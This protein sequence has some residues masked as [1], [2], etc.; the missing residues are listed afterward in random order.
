MSDDP[1]TPRRWQRLVGEVRGRPG[2]TLHCLGGIHGNEPAGLVAAEV[3]LGT[4]RT[5]LARDPA[6]LRGKL[7]ALAGNLEALNAGDPGPRYFDRDLNRMFRAETIA[8]ARRLPAA[9]RSPEQGQLLELV[10]LLAECAG[11]A[12]PGS[13]FLDLHTFSSPGSPFIYVEDSLPARRAGLALGLPLVVGLEEELEGLMADYITAELGL[14]ALVAE[15]GTHADPGSVGVHEAV[16]WTT[17]HTLGMIDDPDALAGFDTRDLLRRAAGAQAGR[18]YDI[19][20]RI[21]VGDPPMDML[22]RARAYTRVWKGITPVAVRRTARGEQTIRAPADGILFMPN[23][24][25]RRL[26]A[27]DAFFILRPIWRPFIG[28]SGWLR[29]QEWAHRL[30]ALLPG[31]RR[32]PAD[33]GALRVDHDVAALMARDILHLFG[34]RVHRSRPSRYHRPLTRLVMSLWVLPRAMLRVAG[35]LPTGLDEIWV[36]RRHR[37]DR[38]QEA[39][40]PRGEEPG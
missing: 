15:G 32:D 21:T 3:V 8:E 39:A 30:L 23:R 2:P 12:P 35:L 36:V 40:R 6:L 25:Q 19:R 29:G 14:M 18:F 28:V 27:D 11:V 16:L 37:L 7:I 24:Q 22:D 1:H 20:E 5:A 26:P 34:Y 38:E 9:E 31:I 33:P 17:L 13:A 4:L 10:D